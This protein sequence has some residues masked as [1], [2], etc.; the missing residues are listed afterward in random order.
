MSTFPF[1]GAAP[2][3]EAAELEIAGLIVTQI[4]PN[5]R[6]Y[7]ATLR[8]MQETWHANG[9]DAKIAAAAAAETTLAGHAPAVWLQWATVFNNLQAWLQTPIEEID[10]A[11]AAVL[12][13]RYPAAG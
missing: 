7:L 5:L 12:L 10:T 3:E 13:K 6:S 9:M 8:G 2:G 11:P 4:L 1:P